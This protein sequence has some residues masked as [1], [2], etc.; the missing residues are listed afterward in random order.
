MTASWLKVAVTLVPLLAMVAHDAIV[1][2]AIDS[3]D[4][5]AAFACTA[6]IE[7]PAPG[8]LDGFGAAVALHEGRLF[9][10]APGDD[11]VG[12]DAGAV[13]VFDSRSLALLA[14]IHS[15]DGQP[16]AAF[17]GSI[18]VAGK[19][20]VVGPEPFWQGPWRSVAVHVFA[21]DDFSYVGALPGIADAVIW[22]VRVRVVADDDVIAVSTFVRDAPT[23]DG[24][25][26]VRV[27]DAGDLAY[28]WG[29][30][31]MPNDEFTVDGN[32]QLG[33]S[34]YLD[35]DH[36]YVG[37]SH[38]TAT[39]GAVH[40]FDRLTGAKVVTLTRPGA[41]YHFGRAVAVVDDVVVVSAPGASRTFTFDRT[42]WQPVGALAHPGDAHAEFAMRLDVV[43][44]YLAA[45]NSD[46]DGWIFENL[47]P[48]S[49]LHL[50]DAATLAPVQR[51]QPQEST[52][53][54]G[55]GWA[56]AGDDSRL[57]VGALTGEGA[58]PR[59][60][61]VYVYDPVARS[62]DTACPRLAPDALRR[63]CDAV[64]DYDGDGRFRNQELAEGTD[65]CV[66]DTDRDGM[67]DGFESAVGA[68]PLRAD[69]DG[70]TLPDGW[71][72]E[73]GTDPTKAD[74]DGDLVPDNTERDLGSDPRDPKSVPVLPPLPPGMQE[75]P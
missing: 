23:P 53:G 13:H 15:P 17:G 20:L 45:S 26:R 72:M 50:F 41:N 3:E 66:A 40:V 75:N 70:D 29:V 71:E 52:L 47:N 51:L 59:A 58:V 43:G 22:D 31:D 46:R 42:T 36:L 67:P 10:G 34:L 16:A 35:R 9:V 44:S 1:P 68:D 60:G 73:I 27:Y 19:F 24:P 32:P 18:H 62:G 30:D 28:L 69:T 5:P 11:D 63:A 49:A 55:F 12:P 57:F 39:T 25:K 64:D 7:N 8:M 37:Q 54:G 2:S 38:K 56:V 6:R 4:A 61:V 48:N 33:E 14:K 65:P 21:L 74:T